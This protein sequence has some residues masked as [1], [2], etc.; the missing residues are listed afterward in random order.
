MKYR[1]KES[2]GKIENDREKRDSIEDDLH[3]WGK[4][5]NPEKWMKGMTGVG[6]P[7]GTG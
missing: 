2:G 1:V 4:N 7:G 6:G 3:G 5:R